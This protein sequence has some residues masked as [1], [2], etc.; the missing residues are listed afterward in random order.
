MMTKRSV[1]THNE[2][3]SVK[4][5]IEE[6]FQVQWPTDQSSWRDSGKKSV[7][8]WDNVGQKL[9]QK[10][11]QFPEV[12]DQAQRHWQRSCAML[13]QKGLRHWTKKR[14]R[15]R[16]GNG[17]HTYPDR[18]MG[19]G[20]AEEKGLRLVT[21]GVHLVW[22][23]SYCTYVV[24]FFSVRPLTGSSVIMRTDGNTYIGTNLAPRLIY[25]W[26]L[27][28]IWCTEGCTGMLLLWR[29]GLQFHK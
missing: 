2:G 27:Y 21:G 22:S 8:S 13:V 25:G 19:E 23:V 16:P 5:R 9:R 14:T 4:M 29:Y 1:N 10:T 7:D 11:L 12:K 26:Y 18:R 3:D 28:K 15:E 17:R 24:N 20:E 6:K